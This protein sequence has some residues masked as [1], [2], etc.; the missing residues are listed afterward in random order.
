MKITINADVNGCRLDVEIEA[1]QNSLQLAHEQLRIT[2]AQL[3]EAATRHVTATGTSTQRALKLPDITPEMLEQAEQIIR[4]E[5]P[6]PDMPPE[7]G[8]DSWTHQVADNDINRENAYWEPL[9]GRLVA[10]TEGQGEHVRGWI[11]FDDGK[12]PFTWVEE[13]RFF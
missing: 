13:S 6:N 11:K 10:L 4:A 5:R 7:P 12:T 2:V 3:V 8:P 9:I 1:A